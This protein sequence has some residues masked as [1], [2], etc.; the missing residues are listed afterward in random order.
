MPLITRRMDRIAYYARNIWRDASPQIFF[1]VRRDAILNTSD[2]YDPG[3]LAARVN[4]CHKLPIGAGAGGASAPISK[5]SMKNSFY[6]YDLKE[7]ARYFP[8]S[9]RLSYQFGD[10]VT[11]PPCA[12]IVKSRPIAG[13][14]ENS[15]LMKLD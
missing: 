13:R 6:Y 14:N 7:H 9:F 5:I 4:Y 8:R 3:Y 11:V 15:V 10:V 12:T 2:R 1:R